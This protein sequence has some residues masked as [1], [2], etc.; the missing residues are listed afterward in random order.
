MAKAKDTE[1]FHSAHSSVMY[2]VAE[3]TEEEKY[4]AAK[5][6]MGAVA[7]HAR[8]KKHGEQR[9]VHL[10]ETVALMLGAR[11]EPSPDYEYTEYL[12]RHIT[13]HQ[14]KEA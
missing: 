5:R 2:D 1:E 4:A 8:R 10:A 9:Y 7:S 11:Q 6:L 13:K 3:P 12:T 14:K